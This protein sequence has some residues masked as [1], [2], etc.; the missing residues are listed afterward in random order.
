MLGRLLKQ[1]KH[2]ASEMFTSKLFDENTFYPALLKDLRRCK[3][4]LIIESPFITKR[5]LAFLLPDLQRLIKHGVTVTVNTK[6]PQE[7]DD[8]LRVEAELG[9]ALLQEINVQV[10]ITGGH[11]RKLAIL[12]RKIL[13]EGSLNILSQNNSSEVMRRIESVELAWEMTRFVEIDKFLN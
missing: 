3:D 11:H 6:P 1:Q 13:Y 8:Y 10:L 4:E 7:N 9:I 2:Q 12:D 5:R